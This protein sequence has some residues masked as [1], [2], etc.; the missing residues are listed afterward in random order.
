M[1]L[2][3]SIKMFKIVTFL[4]GLLRFLSLIITTKQKN[5]EV[6]HSY[7]FKFKTPLR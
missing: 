5:K 6:T 7:L 2:I 1:I 4:Y 3:R